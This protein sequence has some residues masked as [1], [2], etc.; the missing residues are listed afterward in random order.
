MEL[1]RVPYLLDYRVEQRIYE[2]QIQA[3]HTESASTWRRTS[4]G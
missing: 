4:P 1:V 3:A 2:A